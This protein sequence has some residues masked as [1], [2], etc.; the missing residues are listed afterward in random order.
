MKN[1][2]R[3]P[4]KKA[5]SNGKM[6]SISETKSYEC[7]KK[8]TIKGRQTNICKRTRLDSKSRTDIGGNRGQAKQRDP[9]KTLLCCLILDQ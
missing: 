6:T 4:Q 5:G 7:T 3:R 2:K 1:V 9:V 8:E